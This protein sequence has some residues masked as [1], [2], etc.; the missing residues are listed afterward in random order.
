MAKNSLIMEKKEAMRYIMAG[1]EYSGTFEGK[2]PRDS[3]IM[4]ARIFQRP[5]G[6][7]NS[8]SLPFVAFQYNETLGSQQYGHVFR[9]RNTTYYE[10]TNV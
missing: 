10:R 1:I 5:L 9:E 4:C 7:W 3:Q 2:K 6:I 8:S